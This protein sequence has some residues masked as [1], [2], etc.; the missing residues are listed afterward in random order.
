MTNIRNSQ[1]IIFTDLDGT[2]LDF[3]SYSYEAAESALR[4]IREQNIPLIFCSSKTRSE[5]EFY[6][7]QLE[8]K[9][10]FIAENGGA[11]F[12]GKDYFGFEYEHQKSNEKYRIIEIGRPAKTI[13]AKLNKLRD[14]NG[15]KFKGYNDMSLDEVSDLTGLDLEAA[16][17][18]MKREYSE[19]ID[20]TDSTEQLQKFEKTLQKEGLQC[21]HGGRLMTVTAIRN[22][23]GKAVKILKKLYCQN[24]GL[25][26]TVGIGD[27]MNDLP[28]L[29]EVDYPILL[30]R[31]EENWEG[32]NLPNL[33]K[34]SGSGPEMW[35]RVI[36]AF[37]K[38]ESKRQP[39]WSV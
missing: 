33:Q 24:F 15:F 29:S 13:R 5:Q 21:S 7:R 16:I 30:Q 34:V 35:R 14:E 9:H 1:L 23:K 3:N 12:I 4:K 37:L 39:S 2:L 17:M 26:R 6:Q 11:I 18:A 8:V 25:I 32:L 22:D 38:S 27:A 10:P 28:L 31:P 36:I 19:T 20:F